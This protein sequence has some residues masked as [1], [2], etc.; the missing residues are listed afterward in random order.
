MDPNSTLSTGG[1]TFKLASY[2]NSLNSRVAMTFPVHVTR[3]DPVHAIALSNDGNLLAIGND[4]GRLEVSSILS[5]TT[6]HGIY[7]LTLRF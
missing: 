1:T 7:S 4:G 2:D 3:D 5:S 6:G